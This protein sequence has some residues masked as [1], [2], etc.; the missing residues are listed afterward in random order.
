MAP[1]HFADSCH[2]ISQRP[3][4]Q[5][6]NGKGGISAQAQPRAVTCP[7]VLNEKGALLAVAFVR[8]RDF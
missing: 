1:D 2:L 8:G 7:F 4:T 6:G 3:A 5:E